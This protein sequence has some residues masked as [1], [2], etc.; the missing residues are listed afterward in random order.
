MEGKSNKYILLYQSFLSFLT[1][2][3]LAKSN[4]REGFAKWGFFCEKVIV[5]NFD[6]P[7][8]RVH[9]LLNSLFNFFL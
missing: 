7:R 9:S 6:I 5:E 3:K 8:C 1:L 2:D 4:I